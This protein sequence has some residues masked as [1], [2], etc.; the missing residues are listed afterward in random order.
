MTSARTIRANRANAKAST[1]P[2][3][4][5]GKSRAAQN[6]LRHG[7]SLSILTDPTGVA[8]VENMAHEIAEQN[9]APE[10]IET[11]RRIAEAQID[12]QRVRQARL[13]VLS[14]YL[15][16]P[17]Y[18]PDKLFDASKKLVKAI[19]DL[20]RKQGPMALLPPELEAAATDILRKPEGSEKFALILSDCA[21]QL[22]AMDRYERR[23]LSRRKFAIRAFDAAV[24]QAAA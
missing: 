24:R 13:E 16:D 6:A 19:V 9:A 23:A 8:E 21:K 1:G 12:L 17:E 20:L 7:L 3:T 15:N 11:A 5:H 10:V 4:D 2:R 18:R 22:M 14:R